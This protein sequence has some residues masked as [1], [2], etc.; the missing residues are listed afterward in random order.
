MREHETEYGEHGE[1]RKDG[2]LQ[3]DD[4]KPTIY[5]LKHSICDSKQWVKDTGMGLRSIRGNWGGR[6]HL[7]CISGVLGA[8]RGLWGALKP[9]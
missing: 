8:F 3:P 6:G 1:H 2:K 5:E 4:I 9:N 7:G